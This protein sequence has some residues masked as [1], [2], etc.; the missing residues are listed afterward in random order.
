MP[1]LCGSFLYL[2]LC[3]LNICHIPGLC[4]TGLAPG[5]SWLRWLPMVS[6]IRWTSC[7]SSGVTG[8]PGVPGDPSWCLLSLFLHHPPPIHSFLPSLTLHKECRLIRCH[9][10]VAGS[11]LSPLI[12]RR[13][14]V[15]A[16]RALGCPWSVLAPWVVLCSI[17]ISC[18]VSHIFIVSLLRARRRPQSRVGSCELWQRSPP[19]RTPPALPLAA[20]PPSLP[21]R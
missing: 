14:P 8:F 12:L 1:R 11:K 19:L 21:P 6:G 20:W 5:P 9:L 18:S 7:R 17:C 4:S 2:F 13:L 16:R 10:G 3:W 15:T